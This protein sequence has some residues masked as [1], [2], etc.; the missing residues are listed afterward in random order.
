[1]D[2]RLAGPEDRAFWYSIDR[3]LPEA[4]FDKK[5]RDHQEQMPG[6]RFIR[7]RGSL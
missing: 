4:E 1:M 3:H 6:H 5:V 7:N 2:I